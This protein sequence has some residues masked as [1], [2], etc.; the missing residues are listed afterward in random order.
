MTVKIGQLFLPAFPVSGEDNCR[1]IPGLEDT[2]LLM[3]LF[4]PC[5]D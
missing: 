4:A 5:H 3:G 2:A 1:F